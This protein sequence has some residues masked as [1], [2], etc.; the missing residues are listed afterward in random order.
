MTE[1][2]RNLQMKKFNHDYPITLTYNRCNSGKSQYEPWNIYGV[3]HESEHQ[4]VFVDESLRL[5][6]RQYEKGSKLIIRRNQD[7]SGQLEWQ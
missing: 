3:E 5:Q 4:G 6:L 1:K 7:D 2:M